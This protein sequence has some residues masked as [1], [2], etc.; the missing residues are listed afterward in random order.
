V[1]EHG[2][3]GALAADPQS[4]FHHLLQAGLEEVLT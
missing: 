3:R 4:H 1:I 2:E